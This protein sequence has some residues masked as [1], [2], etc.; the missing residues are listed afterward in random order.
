[1]KIAVTGAFGYS[2]QYIA[3]KLLASNHQVITLTNTVLQ[4]DPFDGAVS[5]FPLVFDTPD[6]LS[7]SLEGCDVLINTYWV[8]F[9]HR[10][11]T[12]ETA[13]QNT[14]KLF[15]AAKAAGIG[16]IIHTSIANPNID[17]P[18]EY[19]RGK[20][21]M[22]AMLVET[23]VPHTILRPTVI[24][25]PNDILINNIAWTLRR[26]P[27]MGMFGDGQYRIRPIHVLDF[28][29]AAVDAAIDVVTATGNTTIDTVGPEDYTYRELVR[30]IGKIIGCTRPMVR[31]P[32]FFGLA[33]A[34]LIGWWHR[35]VFLTREEI[36]GLMAGLL[37]TDTPAT[38]TIKL[39]DWLQ[40]NAQTVGK[41]YASE[42]A[43]RR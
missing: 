38:G 33:T 36:G 30:T 3:R 31:V 11:F 4:N 35:D 29:Q 18:F 43:R 25:G 7:R 42:L 22:E 34:K 1:M 28:A 41:H 13:V 10:N 32:I 24:F 16:R 17:S 5:A 23:G 8:R 40:E 27:V 9:N 26:F 39:S 2:G 37:T 20:A 21:R 19:Y 14:N 12:H 15:Q 6:Q